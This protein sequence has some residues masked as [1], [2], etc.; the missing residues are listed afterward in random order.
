MSEPA[1]MD[2][3]AAHAAITETIL[4]YAEYVDAGDNQKWAQLFCKDAIFDEGRSVQGRSA[5]EALLPKLL[6]LFTATSHHISNI[7]I[8][9]TAPDRASSTSYVYA[10]HRKLDG[11]DFEFWGRYVDELK[12][13]DDSWRF[14]SRKVEQFGA[15]GLDITVDRVPR[16]EPENL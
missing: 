7:R 10:W 14:A 15:R 13:E 3:V 5:I 6:R 2:D 1:V 16:R 9:R 11:T 4:S 8:D 12:F